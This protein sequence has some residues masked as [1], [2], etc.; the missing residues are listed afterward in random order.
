MKYNYTPFT[1]D[2]KK[3][4]TNEVISWLKIIEDKRGNKYIPQSN[5]NITMGIAPKDNE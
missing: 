4:S 5:Y 1:V 2:F 3:W